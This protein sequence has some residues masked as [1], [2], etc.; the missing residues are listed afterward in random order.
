MKN[1][2]EIKSFL[3]KEINT[4]SDEIAKGSRREIYLTEAIIFSAFITIFSLILKA[5]KVK[6]FSFLNTSINVVVEFGV[7]LV[8]FYLIEKFFIE[9]K[10]KKEV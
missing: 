2:N 4:G 8:V 5:L 10:I 7:C 3:K 6:L 9:R 1:V